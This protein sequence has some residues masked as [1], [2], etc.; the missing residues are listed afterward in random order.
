MSSLYRILRGQVKLLCYCFENS[1]VRVRVSEARI[2]AFFNLQINSN[3][4]P[5]EPCITA[6]S[7]KDDNLNVNTFRQF[8]VQKRGDVTV[9]DI[10][11]RKNAVRPESEAGV[12]QRCVRSVS[13]LR[14]TGTTDY[15]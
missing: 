1:R 7:G 13:S 2:S 6:E 8:L 10:I 11:Y 3:S 12:F 4:K 9:G 15:T 14:S 5:K